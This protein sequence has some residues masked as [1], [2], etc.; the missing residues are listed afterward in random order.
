VLARALSLVFHADPLRQRA[1]RSELLEAKT[2]D[3][4]VREEA[5]R[6]DFEETR[7]RFRASSQRSDALIRKIVTEHGWP[8]RSLVGPEG[9]MAA[10]VLAQ[11]LDEE[12]ALQRQCLGLLERAV[13]DG[14][15][16][17][18]SLAYLADRVLVNEGKPQRYGTQGNGAAGDTSRVN[19]NRKALGLEPLPIR[20]QR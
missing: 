5:K 6:N 13:A 12:L 3:Q 19:A 16:D 10:W 11:H 2:E 17:A 4:A 15:A 7:A 20:A 18:E 8:G 1:L 14:E 9:A